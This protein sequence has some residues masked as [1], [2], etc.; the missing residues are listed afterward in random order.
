MANMKNLRSWSFEMNPAPDK[1]RKGSLPSP[2][3]GMDLG[4]WI[5]YSRAYERKLENFLAMK[6]LSEGQRKKLETLLS[7]LRSQIRDQLNQ[8]IPE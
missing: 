6:T 4:K 2:V 3:I 5:N 7:L 1:I 8:S